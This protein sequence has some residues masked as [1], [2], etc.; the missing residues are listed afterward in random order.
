MFVI[1][2]S[3]AFYNILHND[4]MHLS[5][6]DFSTRYCIIVFY[7]VFQIGRDWELHCIAL[8]ST[9]VKFEHT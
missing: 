4:M 1:L 7:V 6:Y 8:D 5:H 3:I 2:A 9:L